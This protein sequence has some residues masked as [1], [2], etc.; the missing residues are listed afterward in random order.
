MVL[1]GNTVTGKMIV[2]NYWKKG[3]QDLSPCF[4]ELYPDGRSDIFALTDFLREHQ[5]CLSKIYMLWCILN[6]TI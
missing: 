6:K 3:C 2:V 5:P 1:H 4:I